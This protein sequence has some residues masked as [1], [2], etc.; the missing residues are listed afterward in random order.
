MDDHP[1]LREGLKKILS[2]SSEF[3]LVG[4]ADNGLEVIERAKSEKWDVLL[5]DLSLPGKHGMEVLKELRK[6]SPDLKILVLSF[7][8]ESEYALRALK[9]GA[10]GYLSKDSPPEM[11]FQAIQKIYAG[12]RFMSPTLTEHL[13]T[14]LVDERKS[15]PHENLSNREYQVFTMIAEGMSVSMIAVK[16]Q[17]SVKTVSTHRAH[18]L[19]KMNFSS[20]LNIIRYAILNGIAGS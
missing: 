3:H 6:S 4:E 18:I 20:D 2:E 13:T 11:L 10:S 9:A 19:E 5:L 16:L 7:H 14:L 17:R 8:P 1:I 15:Q 12:S